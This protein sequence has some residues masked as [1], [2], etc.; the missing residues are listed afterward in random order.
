MILPFAVHIAVA[1]SDSLLNIMSK[2][3]NC[4][5]LKFLNLLEHQV[6]TLLLHIF[7]N[8][9]SFKVK[10]LHIFYVTIYTFC[11]PIC[12]SYTLSVL[13]SD[14]SW[15]TYV[16]WITFFFHECVKA[17]FKFGVF[18]SHVH[19]CLYTGLFDFQLMSLSIS[20]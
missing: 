8:S 16:T 5:F 3:T 19:V 17:D 15:K 12:F 6:F 1:L 11:Y 13:I 20:F 14:Y 4:V 18:N 2:W 10:Y 7:L 9:A